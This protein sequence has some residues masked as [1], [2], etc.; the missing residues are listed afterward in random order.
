M[1]YIPR[2]GETAAQVA[3]TAT[4]AAVEEIL[5]VNGTKNLRWEGVRFEYA[6]WLGASGN[7]GYIDTQSA[8]LCQDGEPPVN[9][10]VVSAHN[11]TF[12]NCGF[13]HLGGV[14]A[15]GASEQSQGIVVANSTFT[16]VSGGGV[17][18]GSAGER[19]A[20]SPPVLLDPALQDRG[21]VDHPE[22]SSAAPSH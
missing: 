13:A 9:V 19:G 1:G 11:I 17:K 6:T 4:T 20:P 15:L 16:D 12:E 10:A 21:Y 14:Y 18:L 8:Y 22:S 5:V 3:A 7:K 2:E